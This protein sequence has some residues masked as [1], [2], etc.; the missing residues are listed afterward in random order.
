MKTD[1]L[2]LFGHEG[3]AFKAGL[4]IAG[5]RPFPLRLRAAGKPL[6]FFHG[7][8]WCGQ[9]GHL[10]ELAKDPRRSNVGLKV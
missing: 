4:P 8:E 1:G 2:R 5:A 3:L 7:L 6:F 9:A 10:A